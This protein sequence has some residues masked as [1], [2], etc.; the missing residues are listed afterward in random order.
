[1][2]RQRSQTVA[3]I[4]PSPQNSLFRSGVLLP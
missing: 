3:L 1:M 2:I 4:H